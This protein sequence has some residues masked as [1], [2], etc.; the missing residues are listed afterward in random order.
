MIDKYKLNQ[1]LNNIPIDKDTRIT[2]KRSMGDTFIFFNYEKYKLQLF[3]DY[4][5]FHDDKDYKISYGSIIQ[6]KWEPVFKNKP[7]LFMTEGKIKLKDK[8]QEM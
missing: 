7:I 1:M 4:L 2:I 5:I 3:D 6:I 8:E